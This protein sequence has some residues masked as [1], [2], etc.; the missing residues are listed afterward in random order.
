LARLVAAS[1]CFTV[2]V[3][4]LAAHHPSRLSLI[5]AKLSSNVGATCHLVERDPPR[6]PKNNCRRSPSLTLKTSRL[7]ELSLM[8]INLRGFITWSGAGTSAG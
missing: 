7:F 6:S 3:A 8:Q 2:V 1:G 5:K 4:T